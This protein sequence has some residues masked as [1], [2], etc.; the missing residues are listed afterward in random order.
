MIEAT[1]EGINHEELIF[2]LQQQ[3]HNMIDGKFLDEVILSGSKTVKLNEKTIT[4]SGAYEAPFQLY[5]LL[6]APT[7][8]H[9]V[10]FETKVVSNGKV[11]VRRF[12]C[13]VNT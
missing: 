9:I 12:Y 3:I 13:T 11:E 10:Y 2:T 7:Q 8:Y 1:Y 6:D 4:V 5:E